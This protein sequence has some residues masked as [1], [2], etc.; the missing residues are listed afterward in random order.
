MLHIHKSKDIKMSTV[1]DKDY[2]PVGIHYKTMNQR[3]HGAMDVQMYTQHIITCN[4]N[5]QK[6]AKCLIIKQ[7]LNKFG[8]FN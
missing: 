5:N 4:I 2:L 3:N 6:E 1:F 7:R 8:I